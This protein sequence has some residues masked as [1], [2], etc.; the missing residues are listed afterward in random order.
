MSSLSH[1][2]RVYPPRWPSNNFIYCA[3]KFYF[4]NSPPPT[5]MRNPISFYRSLDWSEVMWVVFFEP[6]AYIW[7]KFRRRELGNK[8]HKI[9][10]RTFLLGDLSIHRLF[11]G[12]TLWSRP[13]SAPTDQCLDRLRLHYSSPKKQFPFNKTEITNPRFETS[14]RIRRCN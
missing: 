11:S 9:Q 14:H 12:C 7:I 1:S 13:L 3:V 8:P 10:G 4:W 5:L 2:G 6:V